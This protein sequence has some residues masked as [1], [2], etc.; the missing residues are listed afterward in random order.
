LRQISALQDSL[1]VKSESWQSIESSLLERS[2][3]AEK[4]AELAESVKRN[5]EDQFESLKA[6]HNDILSKLQKCHNF[7]QDAENTNNQLQKL[8]STLTDQVRELQSQLYFEIGQK[9]NLQTSLHELEIRKNLEMQQI[10]DKFE[11]SLSKA[12]LKISLLQSEKDSFY[13]QFKEEIRK[14]WKRDDLIIGSLQNSNSKPT[15]DTSQI[16]TSPTSGF[17]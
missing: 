8:N 10:R 3:R 15:H 2:F 9:Q 5:L 14:T 13:E 1:R 6:E 4:A 7:I 12:D 16:Q 17:Y 11:D